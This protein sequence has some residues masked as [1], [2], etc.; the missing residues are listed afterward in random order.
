LVI[1]DNSTTGTT[2]VGRTDAEEEKYYKA[3]K[4]VLQDIIFKIVG[5]LLNLENTIFK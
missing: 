3:R 4:V 2:L 5:M 1:S